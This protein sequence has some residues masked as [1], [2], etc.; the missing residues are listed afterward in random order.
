MCNSTDFSLFL[1]SLLNQTSS[2]FTE[3]HVYYTTKADAAENTTGH[4]PRPFRDKCS[5]SV[6]PD[7]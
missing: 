7:I 2:Q 3:P 1:I 5:P 6:P 4:A